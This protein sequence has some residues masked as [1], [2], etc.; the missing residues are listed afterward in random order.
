MFF[1]YSLSVEFVSTCYDFDVMIN[2]YTEQDVCHKIFEYFSCVVN[3][4]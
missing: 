2:I 3:D 4:N 1:S